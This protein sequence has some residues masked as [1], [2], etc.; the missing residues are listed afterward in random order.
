MS[1]NFAKLPIFS[2]FIHLL[3]II[4]ESEKN[5][6]DGYRT[7]PNNGIWDAFAH[8]IFSPGSSPVGFIGAKFGIGEYCQG[9]AGVSTPFCRYP[10]KSS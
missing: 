1:V 6:L 3:R 7:T 2:L 5:Y 10:E 8:I 4:I 9:R